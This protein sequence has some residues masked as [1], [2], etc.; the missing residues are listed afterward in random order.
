[1]S[2]DIISCRGLKNTFFFSSLGTL[3]VM[4]FVVSW[5]F[6]HVFIDHLFF[7]G[8]FSFAPTPRGFFHH[9]LS[10]EA[11]LVLVWHCLVDG[12]S[13]CFILPCPCHTPLATKFASAP[14]SHFL[15]SKFSFSFRSGL[16]FS[17][18]VSGVR[19]YMML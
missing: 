12:T 13:I 16:F 15:L 18:C 19:I 8:E 4:Y 7:G 10:S 2:R 9:H 5:Y 3:F 11:F 14:L 17:V 6:M 1:M